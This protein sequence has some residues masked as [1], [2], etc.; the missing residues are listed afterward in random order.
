MTTCCYLASMF[1][2]I[3]YIEKYS[4]TTY[5]S[6]YGKPPQ[7]HTYD[8]YLTVFTIWVIVNWMSCMKL[9]ECPFRELDKNRNLMS[10]E[11]LCILTVAL[12]CSV[13]YTIHQWGYIKIKEASVIY[14]EKIRGEQQHTEW[15]KIWIWAVRSL[16]CTKRGIAM[17]FCDI[18]NHCSISNVL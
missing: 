4:L 7:S 1:C 6:D 2:V 14:W 5:L 16:R 13:I 9:V 10:C 17:L 11:T 8:Y 3:R 12:F 18:P 15:Q